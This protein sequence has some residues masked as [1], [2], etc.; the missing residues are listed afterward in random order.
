[1][2]VPVLRALQTRRCGAGRPRRPD[3]LRGDKACSSPG[4]RS[5][6]AHAAHQGHDRAARRPAGQPPAFG[7]EQYRR[8]DATERCVSTWKQFRAV[9]TRC[10]NPAHIFNGTL[11]V[12][13][14]AIWLRKPSE[15][16]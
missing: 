16:A 9:A 14:I 3:R 6:P 7:K 2:L 12:A 15:T 13:A 4:K 11:T 10:D 8:R 1:M 5:P